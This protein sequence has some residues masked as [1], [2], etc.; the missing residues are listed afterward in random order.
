MS[1]KESLK[2]WLVIGCSLI[3]K[4]T[5]TSEFLSDRIVEKGLAVLSYHIC[6][7]GSV[8]VRMPDIRE[9]PL[10]FSQKQ[11]VY[12]HFCEEYKMLYREV[13]PSLSFSDQSSILY[14]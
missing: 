3:V 12:K 8:S 1:V 4:E 11:Q 2:P 14:R 7:T 13:A 6:L 10:P 5:E 9:Y